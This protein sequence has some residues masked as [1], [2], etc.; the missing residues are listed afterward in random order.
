MN[1]ILNI[2]VARRISPLPR[3]VAAVTHT[4]QRV[5]DATTIST[6]IHCVSFHRGASAP[7]DQICSGNS[8]TTSSFLSLPIFALSLLS[9]FS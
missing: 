3:L 4:P 9:E 7:V 2:E 5:A 8:C 1:N 6:V